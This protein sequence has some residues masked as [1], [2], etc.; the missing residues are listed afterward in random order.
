MTPKLMLREAE[1]KASLS[2]ML[3]F[4]MPGKS[5]TKTSMHMTLAPITHAARH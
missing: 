3:N 2:E 1:R 5:L 4:S